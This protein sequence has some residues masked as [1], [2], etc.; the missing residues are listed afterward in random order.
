MAAVPGWALRGIPPCWRTQRLLGSLF[1]AWILTVGGISLATAESRSP[2]TLPHD[3]DKL[4][5]RVLDVFEVPGIGLAV[6]KDGRVLLA[7]GYGIKKLGEPDI[8]GPGTL[9]G[10]ASNTKAFTATALGLLV[11]GGLIAWDDPVVDHLPWFRMRDPAVTRKITV[12]DLLVHRSGLGLGAGDLLLWPPSLYTRKEIVKRLRFIPLATSF[13]SAYAYD[14]ILYLV[15]GEILEAVSGRTWEDFVRETIFYPVGMT[16]SHVRHRA[17]HEG[18]DIAEPH[19]SVE[20]SILL[21]PPVENDN[22]NPAGGIL[23]SAVD[24]A[25]WM[26]VH[27]GKGRL[28]DGTRLFSEATARELRTPITPIPIPRL[29]AELASQRMS[30]RGYALG[31]QVHDYRGKKVVTH[32]GGLSGYASKVT[33]I[34]ELELGVVVLTN[35]E[36]GEAYNSITYHILDHFFNAP[37]TDW[38]RAYLKVRGRGRERS[39]ALE[40]KI[41]SGRK[42]SSLPTLAAE[43][44]SGVYSDSWYGTIEISLENGGLVMRFSKTP[45]LVGDLD[46]WQH[47]TFVVRW[48]DRELRADAFVTFILDH[49]EKIVG[50]RMKPVSPDTDFSYDFQDLFLKPVGGDRAP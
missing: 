27:L 42:A 25:K 40:K 6:V 50:A 1:I 20:G 12:R 22:I 24:M 17:T 9:F 7:K 28:P 49:E 5:A 8:V 2:Q 39:R 19:A 15:A 37:E 47:D 35:Q 3:L 31:L 43:A 46:H 4:V 44:Y 10:I 26:I 13:R 36:S 38:V 21:V 29:P 18:L 11:E 34:P 48:R 33:M 41:L 16:G 45:K 32:T 14:N 30:F 23:S